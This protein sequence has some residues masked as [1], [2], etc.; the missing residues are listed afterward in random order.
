[1]TS[2]SVTERFDRL[3]KM[4][5]KRSLQRSPE[6]S[7]GQTIQRGTGFDRGRV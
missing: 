7:L 6:R 2:N 1:M 5:R 4:I 3:D